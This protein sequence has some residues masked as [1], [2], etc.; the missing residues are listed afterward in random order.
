ML[1]NLMRNDQNPKTQANNHSYKVN[2]V[3]FK[4]FQL[5]AFACR[6]LLFYLFF[7]IYLHECVYF[8]SFKWKLKRF[9]SILFSF[10]FR[11]NPSECYIFSPSFLNV[12]IILFIFLQKLQSSTKKERK[13]M[14]QIYSSTEFTYFYFLLLFI[15]SSSSRF[16]LG[17]FLLVFN[18]K[19]NLE[20]QE[21]W[22]FIKIHITWHTKKEKQIVQIFRL[23]SKTIFLFIFYYYLRY[24]TN[25]VC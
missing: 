18:L 17:Y 6:L 16:E 21:R 5:D 3:A 15:R 22:I 13:N 25:T 10:S 11:W 23:K 12:D 7:N 14:T 2:R 4:D 1:Q 24:S 19:R 20:A 8:R 9:F